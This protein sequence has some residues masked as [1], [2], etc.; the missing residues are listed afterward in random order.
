MYVCLYENK[1]QKRE[2][3]EVVYTSKLLYIRSAK[4]YMGIIFL[5]AIIPK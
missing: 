5:R 4:I 3:D 1:K 2:R